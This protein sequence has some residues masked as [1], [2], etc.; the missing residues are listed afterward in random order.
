MNLKD[1]SILKM[2]IIGTAAVVACFRV[3]QLSRQSP[4]S[5]EETYEEPKPE[6]CACALL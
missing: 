6:E 1:S 3:D 4:E 2:E 5:V